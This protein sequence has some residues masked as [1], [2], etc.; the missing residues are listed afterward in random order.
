MHTHA[1]WCDGK[2]ENVRA[3]NMRAPGAASSQVSQ[4]TIAAVNQSILAMINIVMVQLKLK[5][6][7]GYVMCS[8]LFLAAVTSTTF[9]GAVKYVAK[10]AFLHPYF[11]MLDKDGNDTV[12]RIP[13]N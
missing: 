2:C 10:D 7:L 4:S 9:A 3:R 11:S 8:L 1:S 5:P 12:N 6:I 13:H